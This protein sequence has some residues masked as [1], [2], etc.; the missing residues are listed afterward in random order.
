MDPHAVNW[1]KCIM[2]EPMVSQSILP[3][4]T[5]QEGLSVK[6]WN[7]E[8]RKAATELRNQSSEVRKVETARSPKLKQRQIRH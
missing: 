3:R 6:E 2:M 8:N 7:V 5:C 4:S 1:T